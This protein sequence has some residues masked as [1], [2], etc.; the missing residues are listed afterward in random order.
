M[1]FLVFIQHVPHIFLNQYY[2]LIF[3]DFKTGYFFQGL[4]FCSA[5]SMIIFVLHAVFDGLSIKV[6][7]PHHLI[8]GPKVMK[9]RKVL[10]VFSLAEARPVLAIRRQ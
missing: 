9:K 2:S 10:W 1:C 3:H 4:S 7:S 8:E 5:V 6:A